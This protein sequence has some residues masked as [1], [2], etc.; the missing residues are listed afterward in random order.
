MITKQGGDLGH[1]WMVDGHHRIIR[2]WRA[3]ETWINAYI[4][5]YP[6]WE[7]FVI[8]G[9]PEDFSILDKPRGKL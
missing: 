5:V 2:K 3:G 4:V 1:I 6:L 8:H 9:V 7:P